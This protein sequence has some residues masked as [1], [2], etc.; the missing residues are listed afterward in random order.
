MKTKIVTTKEF[1]FSDYEIQGILLIHLK[2]KGIL[3]NSE[4]TTR[5]SLEQDKIILTVIK[6]EYL[7]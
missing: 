7:K 4:D 5:I 6:R 2:S 3:F 1:L